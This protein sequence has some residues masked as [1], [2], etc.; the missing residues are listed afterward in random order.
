MASPLLSSTF[1]MLSPKVFAGENAQYESNDDSSRIGGGAG[2][3]RCLM[4]FK[5]VAVS[6]AVWCGYLGMCV[7][8]WVGL[9]C[10]M[11]YGIFKGG[12]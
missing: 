3:R 1:P 12:R 10:Y 5:T 6:M 11:A 8:G 7:G 2:R 9:E 4:G